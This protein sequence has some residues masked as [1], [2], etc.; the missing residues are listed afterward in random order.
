MSTLVEPEIEQVL[1]AYADAK[2]RH[3]VQAAV[4]LCHPEGYYESVGLAG[5]AQGREALTAFY[6]HFF[7]LLPDYRGEFDGRAFDGDTAVVWGRFTG[8]VSTPLFDGAPVGA[9][10]E[11]PVSFVCT[12]RDG[13]IYSDTGYFDAATLYR[14]AGLAI[15]SLDAYT[16]AA[17]FV[18]RF[19]EC[20]SAPDPRSV[21]SRSLGPA[22]TAR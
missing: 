9:R 12:F 15:P 20:W 19:G 11:V 1:E 2:N 18:S 8:T 6:T 10:V 21:L 5:R 7:T 22:P 3:D 13:L 16:Q 14:Q 17:A 4:A